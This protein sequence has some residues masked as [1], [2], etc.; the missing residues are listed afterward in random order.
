MAG[1]FPAAFIPIV[2]EIALAA[3]KLKVKTGGDCVQNPSDLDATYDGHKGPGYQVQLAETMASIVPI[4]GPVRSFFGNSGAE[5]NEAALK[6]ARLATGRQQIVSAE[7]GYHG[8][9][10]GSLSVTGVEN[11]EAREVTAHADSREFAARVRLDTPRE[12]EYF[13]H[14]GILPFV[15]R[16]LLA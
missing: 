5:A 9:T 4:S 10:F 1:T 16:R 11:G 3:G 15:L 12:R 7:H 13:R 8:R 6:F 2:G 14:G